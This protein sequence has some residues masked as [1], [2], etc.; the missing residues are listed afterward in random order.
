MPEYKKKL[1]QA[2]IKAMQELVVIEESH[3]AWSSPIV[4]VGKPDGTIWFCVDYR[5]VNDVSR[6]D[7]YSMP[8]VDELLDRL[9][10]ANFFSNAGFNQRLLADSVVSRAQGKNGFLHTRWITPI[11]DSSFRVIQKAPRP[12]SGG[13]GMW[14]WGQVLGSAAGESEHTAHGRPS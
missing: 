5:K 1:A 4:L 3:S 9:G 14:W 6:F 12:K 11:P 2:G 13:G 10:T 8:R 7:A